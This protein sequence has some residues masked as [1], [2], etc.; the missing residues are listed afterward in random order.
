MIRP[1]LEFLSPEGVARAIDEAYELLLDPGVRVHYDE[2]LK[3]LADAGAEVDM[4]SRVAKIPRE[5][6]EK[7]VETAPGSFYLYDIDGN[8]AV[9]YGGDDIHSDP[10]SAAIEIAD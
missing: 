9:H 6:A 4:A 7:C 8:P 5:L 3:L 10:G 1:K 2:A